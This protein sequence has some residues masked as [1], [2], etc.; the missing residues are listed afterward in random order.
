MGIPG[1]TFSQLARPKGL[2]P[3]SIARAVDNT[4][5]NP[6]GP[7][8]PAHNWSSNLRFDPFSVGHVHGVRGRDAKGAGE[9]D[10]FAQINDYNG[11]R[12]VQLKV[13]DWQPAQR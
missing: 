6:R 7:T 1:R 5:T 11:H 3:C 13:L 4:N 9:D 2:S 10:V 8:N 12:A